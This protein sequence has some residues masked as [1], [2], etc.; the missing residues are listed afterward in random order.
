MGAQS[1]VASYQ[2][3]LNEMKGIISFVYAIM[4]PEGNLKRMF[5]YLKTTDYVLSLI[6]IR[7]SGYLFLAIQPKQYLYIVC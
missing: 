6:K 2:D 4:D 7:K 3:T 1:R 5:I